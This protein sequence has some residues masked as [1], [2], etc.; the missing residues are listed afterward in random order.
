MVISK[1]SPQLAQYGRHCGGQYHRGNEAPSRAVNSSGTRNTAQRHLHNALSWATANECES[2]GRTTT[3]MP[4]PTARREWREFGQGEF[5]G[6]SKTLMPRSLA[7]VSNSSPHPCPLHCKVG[8]PLEEIASFRSNTCPVPD[9]RLACMHLNAGMT[10]Q[11]I[12]QH[13]VDHANPPWAADNTFVVQKG[14]EH[15]FR[16]QLVLHLP[17]RIVLTERKE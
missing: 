10:P 3:T 12:F 16:P 7:S 1:E 14:E 15:L 5:A 2:S 4:T 11:R 8:S 17:E 9:L 13:G 6:V